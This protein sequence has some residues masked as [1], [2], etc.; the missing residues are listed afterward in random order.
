MGDAP[1]VIGHALAT[2]GT[3]GGQRRMIA[4]ADEMR[5]MCEEKARQ[6]NAWLVQ[7]GP[8]RHA[9]IEAWQYLGQRAGVV[10]RTVETRE[11]RNPATGEFEGILAVAEVQRVDNGD[12]IGRAEQVCYA[13][14]VLQKRDE[15]QADGTWKIG[16][17]YRRW[18]GPDGLPQR[19][20]I[21]GMA[22]TRAQSRALASVLRFLMEMAG[23]A[24]TPAEEMD[25]VTPE[26][27]T[28]IKKPESKSKANV[29]GAPKPK[30]A[31][32]WRGL[33]ESIDI[34]KEGTSDKGKWTIWSVKGADFLGQIVFDGKLM[35]AAVDAAQK[36]LEVVIG[37]DDGKYGP[38]IK[39]IEVAA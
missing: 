6:K 38:E 19:H 23:V 24:G 21:I 27:D 11:L 31:H 32:S 29:G 30:G 35:D 26:A 33:I 13:G 15:K 22:Q 14:E 1:V 34:K 8:S 18:D 17:I 12:V 4:L 3:D 9:R 16:E 28:E 5:A 10:A 36:K 25:G 37:Y 7:I 20:A 39:S 2:F